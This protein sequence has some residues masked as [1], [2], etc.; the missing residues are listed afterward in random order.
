MQSSKQPDRIE[1]L[2]EPADVAGLERYAREEGFLGD[3]EALVS[4]TRAGEG[5][6]NLTLRLATTERTFILKQARP[7]VEKYPQIAAPPDRALVEIAFYETVSTRPRLRDAM[8]KLLGADRKA[9]VVVLEDLGEAQDFTDLYGGATLAE[10]EL[11]EL[12]SYA[13]TL[14]EPFEALE[15]ERKQVFANREMRALNHH[16]IFELPLVEDNGL[17]LDAITPGLGDVA[18][19]LKRDS[20]YLGH[21]EELGKLYLADGEHLVHGDYFPGSWLRTPSGIRVIDPEFC[22]LGERSFDLGVFLAHLCLARQPQSLRD[23]VLHAYGDRRFTSLVRGFAGV[24]IMRRLLGVAQLPLTYGIR[25]K[26]ELLQTSRELVLT[27][28]PT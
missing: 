3:R 6:M 21:V 27:G 13:A 1:F 22:F 23:A 14:H 2:V 24:E 4:I 19:S 8:P 18:L 11:G 17:D 28:G 20:D 7:W 25:E 15:S 16:H 10:R 5:N 12:L 9:R 26:T